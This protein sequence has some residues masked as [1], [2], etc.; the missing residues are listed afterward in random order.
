[1]SVNVYTCTQAD[2][3]SLHKIGSQSAVKIIA[4]RNEVLAGQRPHITI[5][6]LVAIRLSQQEWQDFIDSGSFSIDPI[7][8]TINPTNTTVGQE[9]PSAVSTTITATKE[10]ECFESKMANAISILG[11]SMDKLDSNFQNFASAITQQVKGLTE[12]VLSIQD[13]NEGMKYH[14]DCIEKDK[15]DIKKKTFQS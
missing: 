6:D 4:L 10:K 2:L 14:I 12:S 7:D 15:L 13:Q 1:M 11:T 9:L 8:I 5:E 3:E